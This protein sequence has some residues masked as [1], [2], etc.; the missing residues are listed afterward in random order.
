MSVTYL[1]FNKFE[2]LDFGNAILGGVVMKGYKVSIFLICRPLQA[3]CGLR[4]YEYSPVRIFS[5]SHYNYSASAEAYNKSLGPKSPIREDA[6]LYSR[7]SLL[8][9]SI[10]PLPLPLRF[11]LNYPKLSLIINFIKGEPS[12]G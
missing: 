3:I 1:F 4:K 9:L 12:G 2:K 5:L 11:P 8:P 6:V 10:H 7:V